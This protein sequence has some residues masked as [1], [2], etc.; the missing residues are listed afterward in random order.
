[1]FPVGCSLLLILP[2]SWHPVHVLAAKT[3]DSL[4][5]SYPSLPSRHIF[6]DSKTKWQGRMKLCDP[7]QCGDKIGTYIYTHTYMLPMIYY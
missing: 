7:E 5:I 3:H 2:G 1:M 4:A 6:S